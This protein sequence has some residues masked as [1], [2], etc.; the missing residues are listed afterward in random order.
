MRLSGGELQRVAIARA[1]LK[2][3]EIILLDEAT[4]MIDMETESQ[5]QA[6]LTALSENRTMFV[7][8][9][10]LSTIMNADLILVVKE[11]TII[12]R[13]THEELIEVPNGHYRKL[14]AKQTSNHVAR[15]SPQAA[16]VSLLEDIPT[17]ATENDNLQSISPLVAYPVAPS[18][19]RAGLQPTAVNTGVTFSLPDRPSKIPQPYTRG[20]PRLFPPP[21]SL[22]KGF[23]TQSTQKTARTLQSR[24]SASQLKPEAKEFV[25]QSLSRATAEPMLLQQNTKLSTRVAGL[26]S[27]GFE[28]K[29]VSSKQCP[30]SEAVVK[31]T[32][33]PGPVAGSAHRQVVS[34]SGDV[35][36]PKSAGSVG[37]AEP[38]S[39]KQKRKGT[40][41]RI[42]QQ[43]SESETHDDTSGYASGELAPQ[44]QVSRTE[45]L[46][47]VS[48]SGESLNVGNGKSSLK[49]SRRKPRNGSQSKATESEVLAD[50]LSN[51]ETTTPNK[52]G[53]SK[54]GETVETTSG[55]GSGSAVSTTENQKPK[56]GSRG[57]W[58]KSAKQR[59][60]TGATEGASNVA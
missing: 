20:N 15:K 29:N 3:P 42:P 26:D 56:S 2:N 9:H 17:S 49:D 23:L 43:M 34:T 8:A 39:E 32:G 44:Q 18:A 40:R 38:P 46:D 19:S 41:N 12:E 59:T 35:S 14:W 50:N 37:S 51:T 5:I 11:G 45:A 57:S 60:K 28:V 21:G 30:S 1:I 54:A 53:K 27:S 33:K 48:S 6:A 52:S 24:A 55:S 58:R 10:R 36:A 13:G 16:P 47:P 31:S 22:L 25:P 4:S 7:V